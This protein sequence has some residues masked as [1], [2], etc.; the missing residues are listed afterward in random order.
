MRDWSE[1]SFGNMGF[2][3]LEFVN[4]GTIEGLC[5]MAIHDRKKKYLPSR[6]AQR[7]KYIP[8]ALSKNLTP[9]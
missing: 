9:V 2:S 5:W 1:R 3:S 4:A 8:R 7:S 6:E